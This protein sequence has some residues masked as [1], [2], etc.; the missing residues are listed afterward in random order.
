[1]A[2]TCKKHMSG[3]NVTNALVTRRILLRPGTST[4]ISSVAY[5]SNYLR[6]VNFLAYVL[7]VCG[8]SSKPWDISTH[9]LALQ[10]RNIKVAYRYLAS[11]Y[12][13]VTSR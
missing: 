10:T 2:E 13:G 12:N 9:G 5:P 4:I 1:M 7:V 11:L 6:C 3:G 8:F